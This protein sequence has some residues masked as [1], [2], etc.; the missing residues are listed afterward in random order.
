MYVL[1]HLK[2]EKKKSFTLFIRQTQNSLAT[3]CHKC[4]FLI[5]FKSVLRKAFPSFTTNLTML[6]MP[7]Y[8]Q[9]LETLDTHS[10]TT[11]YHFLTKYVYFLCE[12]G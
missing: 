10:K 7:Q 1:N 8:T 4:L 6:T 9:Y 3:L 12:A 5:S 2:S 11:E